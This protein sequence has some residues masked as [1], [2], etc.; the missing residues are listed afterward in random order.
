[1]PYN[2]DIHR[3]RSIRLCGYDYAQPGAYFIT[4][5]TWMQECLFGE[6]M[7]GD[8]RLNETGRIVVQEWYRTEQIRQNIELDVWVVMPNHF[9]GILLISDGRGT[10]RRAPTMERFAKPVAG[11]IPTIVRS[12]KSAVTKHINKL[13]GTSAVPLWQR[14]YWE[15]IIRDATDLNRIQEY[16]R[17]NPARWEQD[18]L[19]PGHTTGYKAKRLTNSNQAPKRSH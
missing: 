18:A 10:A 15:H 8:M 4:L 13:R 16:I 17:N 14:N 2:P 5:C 3:R 9:H 12:F 19:Y 11:S 1:M 7:N 6:I